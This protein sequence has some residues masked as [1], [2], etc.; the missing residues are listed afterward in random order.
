MDRILDEMA[1]VSMQL[2]HD[3]VD[4]AGFLEGVE[5][6]ARQQL[7]RLTEARGGAR[8]VSA[9][10][11]TMIAATDR[12]S[13]VIGGLIGALATSTGQV[14]LALSSSQQVMGWVGGV[15]GQLGRID[16][17][18]RAASQSNAR[19]L[20][21]A[22]E[23][24]LL[25]INAKIEAARAGPAGRGFA[26]VADAVNALAAQATDAARLISDT[27]G[28]LAGEIGI[29]QAEAQGVAVQAQAGMA[30]LAASE[31]A[32]RLI[33]AQAAQADGELSTLS[34]EAARLRGVMQGFAP[35]FRAL[36]DEVT[37]QAGLVNEARD[38]VAALVHL[39]EGMVQHMF[40]LGGA[41]ADRP[42]IDA[43]MDRARQI[44]QALEAALAKGEISGADLFSTAYEPVPGTAPQQVLA[45]F[46]ALT[47]RLPPPV[48]EPVLALDPRV[49]FCAAVNR[50][51]YLPTHNRKFSAPQGPDPVWNAAHCRNRRIFADRV[52]QAAARSTAP[53]LMQI[54]RR[55]M[56]GDNFVMMK[57]VSAPILVQGQHWGALR[58][59]YRF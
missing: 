30:E 37:A 38:R 50:T 28:A 25:A 40:A 43:A 3:I 44:G 14:G 17:A 58:L 41:T 19:V 21:I 31:T 39:G 13:S 23:V 33:G 4:V 2:G 26:V 7:A 20:E 56:G 35:T 45:P 11:A 15:G 49:V 34:D 27:V 53:F 36:H 54:Y 8:G 5:S 22:R 42:L 52:G 12:L 18:M 16:Q 6:A 57:D 48:Q 46:T 24:S 9:A 59:A 29:L 1:S 55:D 32:L 47:D 10:S 51:G